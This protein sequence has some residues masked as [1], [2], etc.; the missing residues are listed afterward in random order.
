MITVRVSQNKVPIPSLTPLVIHIHLQQSQ[1]LRVQNTKCLLKKHDT[2][3]ET[4]TQQIQK[5]LKIAHRVLKFANLRVKKVYYYEYFNQ[6]FHLYPGIP[7][8]SAFSARRL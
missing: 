1:K 8:I 7:N 6:Y 5:D 3:Y 4:L 2:I